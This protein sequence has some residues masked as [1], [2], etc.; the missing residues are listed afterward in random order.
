MNGI[1][2]YDDG[3]AGWG[4]VSSEQRRWLIGL[5]CHPRKV[6]RGLGRLVCNNEGV[7]Q[8][9]ENRGPLWDETALV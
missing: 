5:A 3:Q 2:V 1:E 8:G 9:L 4:L 6:D 7:A